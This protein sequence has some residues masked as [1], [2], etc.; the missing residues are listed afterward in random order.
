MY[1]EVLRGSKR[2]VSVRLSEL[3]DSQVGRSCN[4]MTKQSWRLPANFS[5]TLCGNHQEECKSI[6][7]S[8][9]ITL[10][11]TI[12]SLSQHATTP[13]LASWAQRRSRDVG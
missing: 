6:S 10:M 7:R 9:F 2:G 13:S 12:A 11:R 5:I 3:G 8:S 1:D 4:V